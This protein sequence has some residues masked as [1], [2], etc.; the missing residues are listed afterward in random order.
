MNKITEVK[1]CLTDGRKLIY[2]GEDA[3]TVYDG[4]KSARL[5]NVLNTS[6]LTLKSNWIITFT[7]SNITTFCFKEESE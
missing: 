7:L 4:I 3:K 2:E 1:I 6:P 5:R